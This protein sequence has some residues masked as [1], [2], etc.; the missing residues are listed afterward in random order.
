MLPPLILA[1][2]M[3]VLIVW[4][5]FEL[6]DYA[7]FKRVADSR[8]RR[9]FYWR[10][11]LTS[12]V[13][14]GLGALLVLLALGR[15]DS[16]TVFPAEFAA[17]PLPKTP[18]GERAAM[19]NATLIG[20]AVG[21]GVGLI[22]FAVVWVWR[23]RKMTQPVIGDV[24]P[25]IPRN[26]RE[27]L[28]A[29]PLAINAGVS[30]ELFFRLMLPLLI[31]LVTGSALLGLGLS[32]IVFGLVHWYQGWKGVLAVTMVGAFLTWLYLTSG[33]LLKPMV[34]HALIDIVALVV[35]PAISLWMGRD[36]PGSPA[37]AL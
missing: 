2:V 9:G 31:T 24:E 28:A 11:T 13:I 20:M 29:L 30:E 3:L 14:L 5:R 10:W 23:L 8:Q 22:L 15:L 12:F 1:L 35:R 25:M 16:L 6:R 18:G 26:R 34:I 4:N 27:L 7:A 32:V 19:S 17:L 21:A 36:R 33:S 37:A